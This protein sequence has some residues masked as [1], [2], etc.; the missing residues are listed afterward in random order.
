MLT[1][2]KPK[3]TLVAGGAAYGVV[4]PGEWCCSAASG[5]GDPISLK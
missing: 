5:S 3:F 1:E 2:T 4:C